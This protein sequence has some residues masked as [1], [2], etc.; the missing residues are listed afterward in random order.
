MVKPRV[1]IPIETAFGEA[2]GHSK[3][4]ESSR[5]DWKY[6]T[7]KFCHWLEQHC[8][9]CEWWSDISRQM[10]REYLGDLGEVGSNTKRL[11]IQPIQQ[12]ARY[13]EREYDIPDIARELGIGSERVRPTPQVFLKDV[14]DFCSF[15]RRTEPLLEGAV[16]LQALAGLRLQEAIRMTWEDVD[17]ER[18]L[19]S[20]R[21]SKNRFSERT[22]PVAPSVVSALENTR[23]AQAVLLGA[24]EVPEDTPVFIGR[25]GKGVEDYNTYSGYVRRCIK[26]WNPECGWAP[27]DLRKCLPTFGRQSG[28]NQ[29]MLEQ[30]IG[31]GA[32]DVTGEHYVAQFTAST[33][34]VRE[35]FEMCMQ[36]LRQT[37]TQPFEKAIR[38][39]GNPAAPHT[40]A[41]LGNKRSHV[42]R[43]LS[44]SM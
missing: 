37:V 23:R 13:L 40:K 38:A 42:R 15:V 18:G 9:K 24:K 4:R 25:S 32:K 14:L 27:M 36:L 22:I 2:L 3:R 30:Y 10:L 28:F 6:A 33:K 12:T 21:R 44:Q 26:A 5:Q 31:H 19:V 7:L 34:G 39:G 1:A 20:I 16:A 8:P 29:T 41:G 35:N 11:A 43:G 17:M